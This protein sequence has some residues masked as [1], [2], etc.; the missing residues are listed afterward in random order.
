[1]Q[2]ENKSSENQQADGQKSPDLTPSGKPK[3]LD[4]ENSVTE[5]IGGQTI[6][7]LLKT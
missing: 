4:D 7:D 2:G 6:E 5:E 1:M 3:K